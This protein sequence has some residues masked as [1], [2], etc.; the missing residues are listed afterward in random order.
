M[1]NLKLPEECSKCQCDA[2]SDCGY[3][4]KRKAAID[5]YLN[6]YK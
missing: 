1:S 4:Y 3:G 2:C 5:K 6:Q